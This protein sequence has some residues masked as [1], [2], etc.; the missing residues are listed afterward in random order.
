MKK[1]LFRSLCKIFGQIKIFQFLLTV[2]NHYQKSTLSWSIFYCVKILTW[3]K[4]LLTICSCHVTFAFQSESTLY[5]CPNVKEL[6]ARSKRKIWSLSDCN[7]T[8]THDHLVHKQTRN[9]LPKLDL[10]K[11]CLAK[12]WVFVKELSGC[13]FQFSCSHLKMLILKIVKFKFTDKK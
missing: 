4:M 8:R 5:S 12:C 11:L 7:Y 10:A 1:Y 9:H 3:T 6:L 2:M 13:G